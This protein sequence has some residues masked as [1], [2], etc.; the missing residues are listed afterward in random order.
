MSEREADRYR[1]DLCDLV[2]VHF[3]TLERG[4]HKSIRWNSNEFLTTKV[5][6]PRPREWG[7]VNGFSRQCRF[8]FL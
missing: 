8:G 4:H 3:Q 1:I 5:H 6:P 2:L 7:G